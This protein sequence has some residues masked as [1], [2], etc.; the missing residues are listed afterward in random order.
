MDTNEII[1]KIKSLPMDDKRRIADMMKPFVWA[2]EAVIKLANLFQMLSP[3]E[4]IAF[5]ELIKQTPHGCEW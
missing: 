1:I 5:I 4:Q 3:E 2:S